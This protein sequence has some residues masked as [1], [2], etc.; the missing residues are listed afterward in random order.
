[1]LHMLNVK[2]IVLWL[3]FWSYYRIWRLQ[4]LIRRQS[5]TGFFIANEEVKKKQK[6][7]FGPIFPI[8]LRSINIDI[9]E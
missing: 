5:R 8:F 4:F 3:L 7:D 9:I 1:M 6:G 2:I